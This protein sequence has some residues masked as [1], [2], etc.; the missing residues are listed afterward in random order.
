M[1]KKQKIIFF[2]GVAVVILLIALI[3]YLIIQDAGS[4]EQD[5][6]A[7][8]TSGVTVDARLDSLQNAYDQ[9]EL[10]NEFEQIDANFTQYED[11][12]KYLKNDTLVT[13]Y[14]AAKARIQE[15]L[16]ELKTEK[17]SNSQNREKI[18]QL[19]SEVE[20]LKGIARH[21]LEEI[22]RLSQENSS[23]KQEIEQVQARNTELASAVSSTTQ[24]NAQ[25]RETVSIARKLNITGLSLSMYGKKDKAAKKVNKATRL[26]VSFTVAPNNTASSGN[27]TFYARVLTPEGALLGGGVACNYSGAS[28]ACSAAKTIEYDNREQHISMYIPVHQSLSAGSYTVDVF[29]DGNRLGSTHVTLGGK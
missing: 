4:T 26:C 27:K 15:L 7:V 19:Q 18:K 11:Q 6:G 16:K 3:V 20:T 17:N 1:N 8:D 13:Q 28:V 21:Y 2:S 12:Q 29:C 23:L 14:N 5:T 10:T 24:Q 9:L 25:L 22:N